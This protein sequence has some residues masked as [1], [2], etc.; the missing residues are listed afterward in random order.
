MDYAEIICQAVDEIVSKKLESINYDASIVCTILDDKKAETGEYVVTDGST[1]FTAYSVSTN[2]KVNDAVYVT[3][4]NNDW[5]EQKIIVGKQITKD[6]TP[7][8]FTTPFD[9]IVDVSANLIENFTGE[10]NLLANHPDITPDGVDVTDEYASH[11][12]IKKLIWE[13]DY[14]DSAVVGFTRLG[15]QGQF[16]SWLQSYSA[17]DGDYGYHLIITCEKDKHESTIA[18]NTR[19]FKKLEG[20]L[21][22]T[23]WGQIMTSDGVDWPADLRISWDAFLALSGEDRNQ[24]IEKMKTILLTNL[25]NSYSK[26]DLYLSSQDMYGDPYNF[27]TYYEQE[28][29]F[30]ISD[31]GKIIH[32]KLEFYQTPKTFLSSKI[33]NQALYDRLSSSTM[34]K[35]LWDSIQSSYQWADEYKMSWEDYNS[36][37]EFDQA[38]LI[39][40]MKKYLQMIPYKHPSFGTLLPPNLFEKDPYICVGYD[41][42][43]FNQESAILYTLDSSSYNANLTDDENT[44]QVQLRWLHEFEDGQIKPVSN[45][46]DLDFE[47][48]W[49]QYALGHPT[50]DGYGGVNWKKV[51]ESVDIEVDLSKITNNMRSYYLIY[52]ADPKTGRVWSEWEYG[53]NLKVPYKNGNTYLLVNGPTVVLSNVDET[54]LA[55]HGLLGLK[56]KAFLDASYGM[57]TIN[58]SLEDQSWT[59]IILSQ[60]I[61]HNANYTVRDEVLGD[62]TQYKNRGCFHRVG[63]WEL[64][65]MAYMMYH[66]APEE[67]DILQTDPL[68]KTGGLESQDWIDN[69]ANKNP[70]N[71]LGLIWPGKSQTSASIKALR[72]HLTD[73]ANSFGE[74]DVWYDPDDNWIDYRPVDPAVY[75]RLYNATLY[76][77]QKTQK[78]EYH[79]VA[80]NFSY[81]FVPDTEK[82]EEKVKAVIM[83]DEKPIYSN[84]LTFTNERI[85][86][87]P[88]TLDQLDGLG[89]ICADGSNGNYRIYS[90]GGELESADERNHIRDLECHFNP[91]EAP[92]NRGLLTE[93]NWIMWRIPARNTMLEVASSIMPTSWSYSNLTSNPKF[94]SL[95]NINTWVKPASFRIADTRYNNGEWSGYL[96]DEATDEIVSVWRGDSSQ[97]FFINPILEYKIKGYYTPSDSNNT[98]SCMILTHGVTYESQLEFTFGPAGTSGTD[99]TFELDFDNNEVALTSGKATQAIVSARLYDKANKDITNEI[100][101]VALNTATEWKWHDS[102]YNSGQVSITRLSKTQVALNYNDSLPM[103]C[104]LYL[105]CTLTGFGDYPL[106]AV[107]PIPIRKWINDN[108]HYSHVTGA[109]YVS[110][111]TDGYPHYYNNPFKAHIITKSS[112]DIS[113][114]SVET[115]GDWNIYNPHNEYEIF[116]GQMSDKQILQ[117]AA[118]YS[119]AKQYGVQ[120]TY[121]GQICWTQP[122]FTFLN[123]YPSKT[124]NQWNGKEIKFDYENGTILAPAI[125]AGKKNLDDNTFSGVML[126]DWSGDDIEDAIG[127]QTGIYG[128]DH[129]YMSYAFKEDGT[130]F[131]G[132]SGGARI[133]FD[134]NESTI[135][136]ESYRLGDGTSTGH[137]MLIDLDDGFIDIL[138]GQQTGEYYEKVPTT[139]TYVGST[140][141]RKTYSNTGAAVHLGITGDPYFRIVAD[142]EHNNTYLMEISNNEYYLQ[143]WNY[144]D[145]SNGEPEAGLLFDLMTPL[146]TAYN[147]TLEST[148]NGIGDGNIHIRF[149]TDEPDYFHIGKD[150]A[151]DSWA[152]DGI[153]YMF[154]INDNEYYIQSYDFDDTEGQEKGMRIDLNDSS[155]KAYNFT[156][157]SKGPG[158][159]SGNVHV[160]FSTEDEDYFFI[161]KDALS[162]DDDDSIENG[163]KPLIKINED[164]FLLQTHDFNVKKEKGM[165]LN[166]TDGIMTAYRFT[167][168]A[169]TGTKKI[170]ISTNA[171]DISDANA[172][173][174]AEI[175]P[176][177]I[178]DPASVFNNGDLYSGSTLSE[179]L[180]RVDWEGRMIATAAR[181]GGWYFYEGATA[182]PKITGDVEKGKWRSIYT[183]GEASSVAGEDS[184]KTFYSVFDP[185]RDNILA[186][187]IP[188]EH[189]FTNHNY[190]KFRILTNGHL[191]CTE[192][193]LG[194]T[195][196]SNSEP[197]NK[198]WIVT[199]NTIYSGG[200]KDD[201]NN[202][203]ISTV[204]FSRQL[205]GATRS[206][207][208]LAIGSNFGVNEHGKLFAE[209]ATIKTITL[210][211]TITGT[212]WN[213]TNEGKATFEDIVLSGTIE[214]NKWNVTAEGVATFENMIA[215]K[216]TLGPFDFNDTKMTATTPSA[217]IAFNNG[218]I[219]SYESGSMTVV[220]NGDL[221]LF[222][223]SKKVLTMA[224]TELVLNSGSITSR[225][226]LS[227]SANSLTINGQDFDQLIADIWD[228]IAEAMR[229]P[230][231]APSLPGL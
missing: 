173:A 29:V 56:D 130:A 51:N 152:V 16:R 49:Y 128:F 230:A 65:T 141:L 165:R 201:A 23:I 34:P 45:A 114:E 107:L 138:G 87:N 63:F 129:G 47:V 64:F 216:G 206:D 73:F 117:P 171:D 14:S 3:I 40:D 57:S 115:G 184:G 127:Q 214:G 85:P 147:F 99:W 163:V 135:Q 2:Y 112:T 136:S 119:D 197:V 113:R 231:P 185:L 95:E 131:I 108:K 220:A 170:Y 177:M 97:A 72:N 98:I 160:R 124:I 126:G 188:S 229:S 161:G 91:R 168:E 11:P 46:T 106:T 31:C 48:K 154:M 228:G 15:I 76:F 1:K 24:Q 111:P 70:Y 226:S 166:M 54:F 142:N 192:A 159:G 198:G 176:L 74:W 189:V 83:Y 118:V 5:R 187:G 186:I 61:F 30:D 37:M 39:A 120:Y 55:K 162:E 207:L 41:L 59:D 146:F 125:A 79:F 102:S 21:D 181:I 172:A 134:G 179:K 36:M 121:G 78:P 153:K 50:V 105:Q 200:A 35:T 158:I 224:G 81:A 217:E 92:V 182:P 103:D 150:R 133:L 6:T 33:A 28:K 123:Q 144:N 84:V 7:F 42:G 82:S 227:I 101:N 178:G 22:A 210:T 218:S 52:H 96:Y 183:L 27:Q 157:E 194:Y 71:D 174:Q 151:N 219:N 180:F 4:P 203:Q 32:M 69:K 148:G 222:S 109:T 80:P 44:K 18:A 143:S 211:G 12:Y 20:K 155:I 58:L 190:A 13:K 195:P 205:I 26:Y 53:Q 132:K 208:R 88:A 137:G 209:G 191:Y 164:T 9:T 104:L 145:G 25:K 86:S 175:Y 19:V 89:L 199:N 116:I 10:K 169:G 221:Y 100:N 68:W 212:K 43:S 225:G 202:F 139:D 66:Y 167:L 204:D 196:D 215:K 94:T 140:I 62:R 60:G 213:I 223:K 93:A 77:Y 193:Y 156:F 110:Y 90:I 122:I 75:E 149:S 8:V 17:I 67:Y 38:Q